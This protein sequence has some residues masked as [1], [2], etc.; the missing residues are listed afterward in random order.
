M[1]NIMKVV[2]GIALILTAPIVF[3]QDSTVAETTSENMAA[4]V[5]DGYCPVHVFNGKLRKGDP[6][7]F[8]V[9]N[10]RTYYFASQVQLDMFNQNPHLY[11]ENFEVKF[12]DLQSKVAQGVM[13]E[14]EGIGLDR[15]DPSSVMAP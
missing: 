14:D 9:Y 11:V 15:L 3:A 7:F 4:P 2:W 5:I 8:A 10:D 13:V 1:K 12:T 6:Q